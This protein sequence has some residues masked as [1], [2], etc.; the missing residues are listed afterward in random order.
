[1]KSGAPGAEDVYDFPMLFGQ[2]RLWILDQMVPGNP[3][4]AELAIEVGSI[5]DG[6]SNLTPHGAAL[7]GIPK[8]AAT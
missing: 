1:M 4:I 7:A 8:E 3:T 6:P 5:V 2:H